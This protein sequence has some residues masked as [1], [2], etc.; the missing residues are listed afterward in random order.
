M[1]GPRPV[2]S[3]CGPETPAGRTTL[4]PTPPVL[5]GGGGRCGAA[6]QPGEPHQGSHEPSAA[7]H[8]AWKWTVFGR[9]DVTHTHFVLKLWWGPR[10]DFLPSQPIFGPQGSSLMFV[11]PVSLRSPAPGLPRGAAHAEC[12]SC[13]GPSRSRCFQAYRPFFNVENTTTVISFTDQ[14]GPRL[15]SVPPPRQAVCGQGRRHAPP[16]PKGP[17]R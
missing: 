9:S 4:E 8:P 10:T 16:A 1:Y 14:N 17:L 5:M 6:Q 2:F 11:K 12:A 13:E 15:E 7:S 3:R